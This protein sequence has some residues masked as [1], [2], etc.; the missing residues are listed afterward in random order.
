MSALSFTLVSEGPSD[1]AL[2]PVLRWMVGRHIAREVRPQWPKYYPHRRPGSL[3]ERIDLAVDLYP[4]DLLFIHRDADRSMRKDRV[5]EI[6]NATAQSHRAAAISAVCVV[7]VKMTEA[8]LLIDEAA[9]RTA[10]GNPQ[11][12]CHLDMPKLRNVESIADPKTLLHK[13]IEEASELTGR[14]LKKLDTAG[15]VM[16]LAELIDDFSPLCQLSAFQEMEAEFL[17]VKA[18]RGW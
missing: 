7:P 6:R 8:W 13:L 11:G 5:E 15:S 14:R 1:R 2:M 16:R 18:E 9:L 17:Q 10:A 3:T 4:C 12:R